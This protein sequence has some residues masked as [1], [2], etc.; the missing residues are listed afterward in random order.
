MKKISLATP[1]L[2]ARLKATSFE[3]SHITFFN[4]GFISPRLKKTNTVFGTQF[5]RRPY[6]DF[7][8][9]VSSRLLVF[10]ATKSHNGSCGHGYSSLRASSPMIMDGKRS[11]LRVDCVASVSSRVIARRTRAETLATQAK[12]REN[13]PASGEGK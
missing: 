7:T 5:N 8:D 13:V 6:Y 9:R 3:K 2:N 11:E 12:L 1:S 4:L 10:E